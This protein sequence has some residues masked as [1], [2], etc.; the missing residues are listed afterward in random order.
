[1]AGKV[2][3]LTNIF[4]LTHTAFNVWYSNP[5]VRALNCISAFLQLTALILTTVQTWIKP[6]A[7]GCYGY[8]VTLAASTLFQAVGLEIQY[9]AT[10]KYRQDLPEHL[11]LLRNHEKLW[12]I[13]GVLC[14]VLP[15]M[16]LFSMADQFQ[17]TQIKLRVAIWSMVAYALALAVQT[18]SITAIFIRIDPDNPLRLG[19][20]I[21][22]S[23]TLA[24]TLASG[25]ILLLGYKLRSMPSLVI[26][27]SVF[28]ASFSLALYNYWDT[29]IMVNR[30]Q[31]Y[32][33]QDLAA[34]QLYGHLL[35]AIVQYSFILFKWTIK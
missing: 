31:K 3:L 25:F 18:S 17:D 24:L 20:W 10:P 13:I 29:F 6:S 27:N 16:A 7:C 21:I 14:L 19:Y 11:L 12:E 15:F 8:I 30:Y 33:L 22:S 4:Y 5:T 32:H 9:E 2:A 26:S 23:I 28:V 34:L 1:M 35:P